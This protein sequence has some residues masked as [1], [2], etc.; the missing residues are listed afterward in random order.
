MERFSFKGPRE[1]GQESGIWEE[2]RLWHCVRHMCGN[3]PFQ[4][5]ASSEDGP[6]GPDLPTFQKKPEISILK[7]VT[8][9]NV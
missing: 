6:R 9:Y 8:C 2:R 1:E 7:N 5:V 3:A 4:G